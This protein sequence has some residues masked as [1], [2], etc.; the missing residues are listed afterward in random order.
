MDQP[1]STLLPEPNRMP[2]P[3]HP[4]P[5]ERHPG[6]AGLPYVSTRGG[7]AD[8][9]MFTVATIGAQVLM[10][11]AGMLQKRLLGPTAAGYWA[12]V[13]ALA[14]IFQLSSLGAL[15]GASRQVPLHR[16]RG[17]LQ[18]AASAA[19]TGA[20][21]SILSTLAAGATL[22]AVALV[23]GGH[24]NPELR[25]GLVLLSLIAPVQKLA[26][27]HETLVQ[28]TKR[29]HVSSLVALVEAAA[30]LAIQTAAVALLG[31]YGMFVGLV[32]IIGGAM[33]VWNRMGVTGLRRPAFRWQLDWERWRELTRFGLPITLN[34]Q[35]WSLFL[36][37]D[38]LIVA[39]FLSVRQLGYYALACST[40][41][42]IM[43]VPKSIGSALAPRMSERFGKTSSAQSIGSYSSDSQQ[44]LAFL[45]LPVMIGAAFFGMPVLIRHAL[46][47]F[48]PAVP[49]IRIVV[50]GSFF[51]SLTTMP[52]KVMLTAGYRWSVAG[53]T[54]AA[55]AIN[56]VANVV[57]VPILHRGLTGA[58]VAVAFSY[59]TA[60]LVMTLMAAAR[61]GHVGGR[62][63]YVAEI[64]GAF[65]YTMGVMWAIE[66]VAG[67]GGGNLV[68]DA[69]NAAA[70]LAALLVLLAPLYVL[71]ERRMGGMS[72]IASVAKSAAH[73][74]LRRSNRHA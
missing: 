15:D 54:L 68:A 72:A 3:E 23:F 70:K 43:Y 25:Y 26:D 41:T 21:F 18:A 36:V 56:T 67:P 46:P 71:V 27:I 39:G 33:V 16:G 34:G 8:A 28:S 40:T 20:A 61:S 51:I 19:D 2:R 1:V 50:A 17:D 13:T 7:G 65:A 6:L 59:A 44:L 32:A 14:V 74:A 12:L 69:L 4:A 37:V 57:A 47:A 49:V 38:N 30:T 73:L 45:L 5:L 11:V 64:G 58:A 62:I 66:L 29:F 22:A 52:T 24:W 31:Y 9:A 60:F 63:R 35:L 42:Y 10:F 55:L 53:L 48:V